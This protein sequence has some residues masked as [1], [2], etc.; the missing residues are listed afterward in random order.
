MKASKSLERT[1]YHEAG[2]AVAAY[3]LN[4]PIAHITIVPDEAAGAAGLCIPSSQMASAQWGRHRRPSHPAEVR[5]LQA[6]AFIY[7]AGPKAEAWYTCESEDWAGSGIDD[8]YH[9]TY[10][11]GLVAE[12]EDDFHEWMSRLDE[13]TEELLREP[14]GVWDAVEA[15]ALT[16]LELRMMDGQRTQAVIRRA[17]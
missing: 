16:L 13:D 14:P 3:L 12:N 7:L 8:L 10:L 5:A 11:V 4:C 17:L 2:H 15:L 1:A 9:V 6:E